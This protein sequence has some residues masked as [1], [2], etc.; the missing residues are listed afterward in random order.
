M[1]AKI[2]KLGNQASETN[3]EKNWVST[4]NQVEYYKR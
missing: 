3:S 4:N 1:E 2:A